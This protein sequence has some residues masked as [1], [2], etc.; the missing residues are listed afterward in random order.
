MMTGLVLFPAGLPAAAQPRDSIQDIVDQIDIETWHHYEYDLLY[1]HDGDNRGR[2]SPQHDLARDN[3]EVTLQS[4]GLETY[5]DW[6]QAGGGSYYNVVATKPGLVTPEQQYIISGHID[7]VG[8]PGADDDASGCASVMEIARVLSQH[9]FASTI[10]FIAFD[11]HE[12]GPGREGS[13]HYANMHQNDDIR[14]KIAMDMIAHDVGLGVCDIYGREESNEIKLAFAAAIE[15]Y[16]GGLSARVFGHFD[17]CDHNPFEAVGKQACVVTQGDG[18]WGN[19]CYHQP[20]DSVDTPGNIDDAYAVQVAR[21]VAGYLLEHAGLLGRPGDLDGDGRV[22]ILDLL[23]LL[24]GWGPC[25]D[26]SAPCP[27]DLDG[28]RFVGIDD[29]LILLAN[30]G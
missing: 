24:A 15:T 29:L 11:F 14:G 26:L 4:F 7:S 17:C 2:N 13:S 23:A 3:V 22:G 27:A 30:W 20:C 16:S 8:N 5:Q 28:D 6:F 25:P 10:I 12:G 21:G 18:P 9:D 19:P 1:T